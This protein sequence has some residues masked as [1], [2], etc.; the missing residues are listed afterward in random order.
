MIAPDQRNIRFR[1]ESP[2]LVRTEAQLD[3]DRI[4]YCPHFSRLADVT[5]VRTLE[6]D[7]LVHNRLTHS[8]KVA[9]IARRITEKL[10]EDQ[11]SDQRELAN[12]WQLNPDVSEAAGLAHDLGH[13]PFGHIAEDELNLLVSNSDPLVE[14][15]EGNAQSFRIVTRLGVSDTWPVQDPESTNALGLNLT[16]ATLNA[17]LKYPWLHL[18][19]DKKKNKWGAYASEKEIF[20]RTREN[21]ARLCRTPEA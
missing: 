11:R 9:Q 7:Q 1:E 19:N 18:E 12:E 8:L 4:L 15:Y 6:S 16:K 20:E 21:L 17:I 5:Q 14:G 10:L 3:R 2:S 13:P